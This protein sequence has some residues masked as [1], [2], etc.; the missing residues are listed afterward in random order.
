MQGQGVLSLLLTCHAISLVP[1]SPLFS[2]CCA[3]G[4]SASAE[5]VHHHVH[6]QQM[7]AYMTAMACP[8][9]DYTHR[10]RGQDPCQAS[11]QCAADEF[12]NVHPE[13]HCPSCLTAVHSSSDS[14]SAQDAFLF[15]ISKWRI[16]TAMH[17]RRLGHAQHFS[18]DASSLDQEEG[19]HAYFLKTLLMCCAS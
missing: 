1:V 8:V 7:K 3:R 13:S 2:C 12:H 9:L 11:W 19:M 10:N 4:T 5:T 14:A 6:L 15:F 16:L 18:F 17:Q